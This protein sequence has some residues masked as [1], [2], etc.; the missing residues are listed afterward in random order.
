MSLCKHEAD[1]GNLLAALDCVTLA[2]RNYHDSGNVAVMGVP[3]SNLAY[4]LDR[5]GRHEPAASILG[6]AFTPMVA[7]TIKGI[8]RTITH[9]REVL[10]DQIYESLA[11]KGEAMTTAAIATYAYDQIGQ[12]R[13]ELN[14]VSKSTFVTRGSLS[15]NPGHPA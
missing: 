1:Y 4:T 5:L 12:A 13:A 15:Q 6:F 14:A 3:L 11:R 8:D 2:I 7:V 9:L 10:G